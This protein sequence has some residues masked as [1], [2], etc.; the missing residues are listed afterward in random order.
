MPPPS[1]NEFVMT[2]MMATTGGPG[3]KLDHHGHYG[4]DEQDYSS[5]HSFKKGDNPSFVKP[6]NIYQTCS[7]IFQAPLPH[8]MDDSMRQQAYG[9][10]GGLM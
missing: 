7:S 4:Q 8:H 6:Q 9:M 5:S 10:S 2:S 3:G 1:D